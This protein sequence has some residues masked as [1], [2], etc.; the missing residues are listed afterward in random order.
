M[1]F[2]GMQEISL[3]EYPGKTATI[4]FTPGCNFRCPYCYNRKLVLEPGRTKK[5]SE[6]SVISFLKKKKKWI[7]AVVV[8]GGEP[9]IHGDL[10]TFFKRVKKL[11]F[12]TGLE[13][14]GSNASMMKYII[15]NKL[16]DFVGMDFKAPPNWE[17]YKKAAGIK[18]KNYFENVLKT[19]DFLKKSKINHE[20]RTTVVPGITSE[21]DVAEIAKHLK[22]AGVYVLQ[23]FMPIT[24]I[25][26]KLERVKPYSSAELER[27][28]TVASKHVRCEVR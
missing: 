4:V 14:N 16:V 1:E 3:I 20:F 24:T 22:N 23:Q 2:S 18:N 28:K 15:K 21:S 13:T 9:T 27:M 17:K 26:R 25:D 10:P 12:L 8:T 6:E 5:I 19:A 11:G 7:D